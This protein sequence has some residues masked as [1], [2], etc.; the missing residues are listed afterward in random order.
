MNPAILARYRRRVQV[1]YQNPYASLDPRFDLEQI[2]CEPLHAFAVGDRGSRRERALHLL[3]RV[4]LSARLLRSRPR[5]LSGG[6]RQ[7]VA[8]ARALAHWTVH[9]TPDACCLVRLRARPSITTT[10]HC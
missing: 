3:K 8:I 10:S 9:R 2:I 7:R 5:E 1:V 4:G 6:Q